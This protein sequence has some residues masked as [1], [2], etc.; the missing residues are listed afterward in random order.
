M[1]GGGGEGWGKYSWNCTSA[2]ISSENTLCLF[3]VLKYSFI[4]GQIKA[5]VAPLTRTLVV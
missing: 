4:P 1:A 2:R 3:G 5:R